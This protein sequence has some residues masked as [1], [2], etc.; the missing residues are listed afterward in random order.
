[1]TDGGVFR[2]NQA[3]AIY[4]ALGVAKERIDPGQSWESYIE[5]HFNV[6]RRLADWHF[7]RGQSWTEVRAAHDRWVADYHYQEHWAH[8]SPQRTLW[9]LGDAEWHKVLR[10]PD[11]APR[12]QRPA[13]VARQVALFR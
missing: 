13:P 1:V 12:R 2:A 11:P 5:T 8:R 6:L 9:E 3:H 7:E 4:G 10:P